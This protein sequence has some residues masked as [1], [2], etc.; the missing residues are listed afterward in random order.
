MVSNCGE[1]RLSAMEDNVQVKGR[2]L[3]SKEIIICKF[4]IDFVS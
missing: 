3:N 2:H 1:E 4:N